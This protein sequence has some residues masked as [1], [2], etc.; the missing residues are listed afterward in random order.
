[1][2]IS[3][4]HSKTIYSELAG[5][6][7]QLPSSALAKTLSQGG[8]WESFIVKGNREGLWYALIGGCWHRRLA[9]GYLEMEHPIFLCDWFG[10]CTWLSLVGPEEQKLGK[11]A[12]IDQVLT[13]LC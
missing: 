6:G 13:V 8:E 11:L 5:Q 12:V 7:S 2:E 1:M 10:D 4:D 9:V 3:E